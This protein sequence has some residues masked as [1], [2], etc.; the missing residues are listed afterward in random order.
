MSTLDLLRYLRD[1]GL[2]SFDEFTDRKGA[3]VVS[4]YDNDGWH[5]GIV[6]YF[7]EKGNVL[8]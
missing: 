5:K 2:I 4:V 1:E 7:D 6:I 3:N 8:E